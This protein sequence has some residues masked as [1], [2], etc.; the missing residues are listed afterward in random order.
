[1]A[2]DKVTYNKVTS[3]SEIVDGG[4][5]VMVAKNGDFWK[6]ANG[7]DASSFTAETF[8]GSETLSVPNACEITLHSVADSKFQ[9][10][11]EQS[12]STS[13]IYNDG[14]TFKIGPFPDSRDVFIDWTIIINDD[15][16]ANV[17]C[18]DGYPFAFLTKY[19]KTYPYNSS[20]IKPIYLY[21]K[22]T[23]P[24]GSPEGPSEGPSEGPY[25]VQVTITSAGY[26][27]LC[28]DQ[29]LDFTSSEIEAYTATLSGSV[30]NLTRITKVPANTAVILYS[31]Q[32]TT[33]DIPTTEETV[34][35]EAAAIS[36][37]ILHGVSAE[38]GFTVSEPDRYYA[39]CKNDDAVGFFPVA[40]NTM[41][42]K[43]KAYIDTGSASAAKQL[44]FSFGTPTALPRV[45]TPSRTPATYTISGHPAPSSYHGI[46]IQNGGKKMSK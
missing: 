26:A 31:T 30:I 34:P 32:E 36:S 23:V 20:D 19:F 6:Y 25:S 3:Q 12:G 38:E 22:A 24:S 46:T 14:T 44:T 42:P 21:K 16:T 39:L 10:T 37:N 2:Q 7:H 8:S 28:S 29:G 33:A 41:I 40:P 9:L 18:N 45:T 5:Y 15:N 1:M 35:A 4:V 13:Y 27:T 11:L 17:Y 43:G